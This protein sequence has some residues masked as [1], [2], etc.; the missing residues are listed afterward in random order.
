MVPRDTR[1]EAVRLIAGDEAPVWRL[2]DPVEL[3]YTPD[4][5]ATVYEGL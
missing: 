5:I 4:T 1:D 2:T 3:R